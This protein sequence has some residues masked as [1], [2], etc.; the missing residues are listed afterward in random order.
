MITVYMPIGLPGSGKSTYSHKIEG[1][2]VVSVDE[3]RQKLANE[4]V[5]GKV[6]SS[7]DNRIVF[8]AFHEKILQVVKNGKDV[9]VDSTNARKIER[10]EVFNLLREFKPKFVALRFCDDKDVC[11]N[12]IEKREKNE[13]GV[14]RFEDPSSALDIYAKRIEESKLSLDEDFAEIDYVKDGRIFKSEKKVLIASTNQG[15]INI[16][17]E[18]CK[19]LGLHATSLAEIKVDIKV[20]ENGR[21]EEENAILKAKAYHK[22]TGLPVIAND[23][24]LVIDKFKQE[25]QPGLLVRRF[26]GKELTDEEMLKVYIDKLN[27]VGGESSGHYNVAL[28][29]IDFKGCLKTKMFYPKRF[30]INK[31]SKVIKKG[32]PLSSLVFDEKSGKYMSEMTTKERNDYEAEAM[33]AQKQ[34]IK[35][36]FER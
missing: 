36:T 11:L 22:V 7:D 14:H 27:E 12:R 5:I 4:G 19:E 17:K 30:F 8:S 20:E 34:F 10:E 2:T 25:D 9:V 15:K 33:Q 16:Y 28:A 21:N 18:V 6:Y 23:S 24:G 29:L 13:N 31:P 35:E 32:V 26:G 3:V 1:A